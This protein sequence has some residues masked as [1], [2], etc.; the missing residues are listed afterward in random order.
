MKKQLLI[1]SVLACSFVNTNVLSQEKN[2]KVEALNEV[3]VTATKFAT[4]KKNVGKVVYQIT[5]ET[6][7][8]S[9][10]KTIVDLLNDV[11]GV[12]INGN[13]STKGQNLGYY[14]RGGRNRQVAILLDGVN[15]NDPSSFNGDFDLRQIDINQVEK[16]EIL[17]GASSTLYGTGAATGVINIILK[18]A[19]KQG[20]NGTFNSSIGS[21]TSSENSNLSAEE[22][23]TNFNFNG[24][25]GKLDYLL[26]L[27]ANGS[28]GLSAAE[29]TTSNQFEEDHFS[30]QNV[31]LKVNY[32]FNENF[33]I[34]L[35][36]S[37]DEFSTDFDGFDFDPVTFASI[38]ADRDNNLNSVQKRVGV[39]ADYTY[40]KGALKIRT[41]F[42]DINRTET[43]SD[44]FFNGEVYG[45]DIYNNYMFN[46][47]FSF[48]AG[49]TSQYQDMIQRTSFSN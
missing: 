26:A 8:N 18:K 48:L 36:T 35:L 37:F 30:R 38:P 4:N 11:P 47:E 40:T 24:T 10:G 12:E 1:V 44:N 14:I 27:N 3:V 43:P 33:K 5:Q 31:M 45:F 6:I 25:L 39:N 34:G 28:S 7:E 19:S 23:S 42:T 32:A 21:N 29:S 41:F 17:K 49:V 2:E 13:F 15:V 22:F 46:D 16:I 20:F 9:Q